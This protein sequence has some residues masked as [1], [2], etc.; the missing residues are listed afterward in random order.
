MTMS[1]IC[2]EHHFISSGRC[3]YCQMQSRY[4]NECWASLQKWTKAEIKKEQER[5]EGLL[6]NLK[7]ISHIHEEGDS[8]CYG[9][10]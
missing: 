2:R 10:S 5:Y 6:E 7:C 1:E 3:A 8:L 9:S 4:Y